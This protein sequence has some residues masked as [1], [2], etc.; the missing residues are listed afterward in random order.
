M[1]LIKF[2]FQEIGE[3]TQILNQDLDPDLESKE[4]DLII[5]V[6][7]IGVMAIVVKFHFNRFS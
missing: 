2:D 6:A 1:C 5:K 4:E 7:E 3:N